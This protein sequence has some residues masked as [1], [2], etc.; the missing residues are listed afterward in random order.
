MTF[1]TVGQVEALFVTG[2]VDSEAD[3]DYTPEPSTCIGLLV[4]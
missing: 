4:F 1:S 2:G 3:Q